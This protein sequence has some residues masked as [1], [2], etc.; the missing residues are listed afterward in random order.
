MSSTNYDEALYSILED[1]KRCPVDSNFCVDLIRLRLEL[2]KDCPGKYHLEWTDTPIG[3]F[4]IIDLDK[5]MVVF[6]SDDEH[7]EWMLRN[8]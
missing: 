6:H 2:L 1:P 7:T 8:G 3:L 5:I 4:D